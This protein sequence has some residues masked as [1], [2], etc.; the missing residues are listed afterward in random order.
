MSAILRAVLSMSAVNALSRITGYMRTVVMAAVLGTGVVA[1][2]YAVSNGIASLIYEL[3]LG[4]ILYQIFI[5]LLV[6][7]MTIHGEEDARRLTN[8]LL[9]VILPLLAVVALLGIVFAEPLVNLATDWTGSEEL[10]AKTAQETVDLTVFFFRFFVLYIFFLGLGSV[11]TGVLNA[12]R[13]FFLP[14][15]APVLN[16]LF[17]MACFG[18]YALLAPRNPEPTPRRVVPLHATTYMAAPAARILARERRRRWPSMRL[19]SLLIA[20]RPIRAK[21]ALATEYASA[22]PATPSMLERP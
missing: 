19:I 17:A 21:T 8:A 2:A 9:T 20:A 11:L 13:R 15:F 16:N 10:S 5:P 6:E 18:G 14:T 4:G 7:R 22:T 3:F 12:H 1:N